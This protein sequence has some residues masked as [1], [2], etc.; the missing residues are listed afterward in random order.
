MSQ[1]TNLYFYEF[2]EN[3][4]KNDKD[5][6]IY[7]SFLKWLKKDNSTIDLLNILIQALKSLNRYDDCAILIDKYL[8]MSSYNSKDFF[9][10]CLKYAYCSENISLIS[11]YTKK[12]KDEFSNNIEKPPFNEKQVLLDQQLDTY[13]NRPLLIVFQGFVSKIVEIGRAHV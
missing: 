1:K 12:I 3:I 8:S 7:L 10:E 13:V 4:L 9:L 6:I 2:I 5:N 11:K